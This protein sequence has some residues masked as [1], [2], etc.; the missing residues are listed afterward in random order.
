MTERSRTRSRPDFTRE[1]KIVSG[2]G[3]NVLCHEHFGDCNP[4]Q[5]NLVHVKN[6]SSTYVKKLGLQSIYRLCLL[7]EKKRLS[8][9]IIR[10]EL[11]LIWPRSKPISKKN[12]FLCKSQGELST[13]HLPS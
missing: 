4:I 1:T 12:V 2:T 5:E 8:L 10:E 13:P 9:S 3:K 7:A 6:R 11:S